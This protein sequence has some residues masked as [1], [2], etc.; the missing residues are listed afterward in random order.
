MPDGARLSGLHRIRNPR[1]P[2]NGTSPSGN[3]YNYLRT[4]LQQHRLNMPI[5]RS[6]PTP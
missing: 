1:R 2:D 5:A 3:H 4:T 6:A